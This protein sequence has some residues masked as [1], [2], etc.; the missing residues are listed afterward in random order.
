MARAA[1][2]SQAVNEDFPSASRASWKPVSR[3]DMALAF[4]ARTLR[5]RRRSSASTAAT[6]TALLELST[7]FCWVKRPESGSYAGRTSAARIDAFSAAV[8]GSAW[9]AGRSF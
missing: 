5:A 2:L 3:S 1:F 9:L 6:S 8:N 7:S 4:S